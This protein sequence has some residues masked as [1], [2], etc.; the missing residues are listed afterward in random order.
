MF[1]V[2]T[3][4]AASGIHGNGVFAGEELYEGQQIWRFAPGLD[5]VVPFDVIAAAPKAFQDYM[6][7]Y[8]YIS[9]QVDGGMVLSCDHAKFLNHSDD[10]NTL[11]DGPIT[12]ARRAIRKGEEITCDYRICVA[13]F[14]GQF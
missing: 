4:V 2:Q 1:I 8:A 6:E 12:L 5:L 14:P 10:P 9:P 3:Y 13:D 7:M 11:I